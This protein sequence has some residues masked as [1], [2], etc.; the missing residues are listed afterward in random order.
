MSPRIITTFAYPPI[1]IRDCDWQAHY[2]GEEDEQMD[3][4][5][6]ETEAEAIADLVENYP[7]ENTD[8]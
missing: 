8:G 5:R 3:V 6:G 7:R 2:A 4:G 1:P